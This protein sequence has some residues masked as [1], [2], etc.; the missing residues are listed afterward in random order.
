M[1]A[2]RRKAAGGRNG[3]PE[4][5]GFGSNCPRELNLLPGRWMKKSKWGSPCP[6]SSGPPRA[7][8]PRA[9]RDSTVPTRPLPPSTEH[10]VRNASALEHGFPERPADQ[11]PVQEPQGPE[12]VRT[13]HP[14]IELRD[15]QF[16]FDVGLRDVLSNHAR[17]LWYAV[18]PE[19]EVRRRRHEASLV[20]R[21]RVRRPL[22]REPPVRDEER[23]VCRVR[24]VLAAVID[25]VDL[26]VGPG[27][28][29]PVA[30]GHRLRER[31]DHDGDAD[32]S[33]RDDSLRP[34]TSSRATGPGYVSRPSSAAFLALSEGSG[35]LE[36][37]LADL[38][39]RTNAPRCCPSFH[40]RVAKSHKHEIGLHSQG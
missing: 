3:C 12:P 27:R 33:Y 20:Q 11:A 38:Y 32:D 25:H 28:P 13:G 26:D 2:K 6:C 30:R 16:V 14:L 8:S 29:I 4:S 15:E 22:G 1:G 40:G 23:C 34:L 19:L 37:P 10:H 21:W 9:P 24:E 17:R 31:E 18:D 35:L 7:T 36:V 5:S 39:I